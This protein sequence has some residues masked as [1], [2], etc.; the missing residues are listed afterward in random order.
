[1]S[2]IQTYSHK[3]IYL[4]EFTDKTGASKIYIDDIAHALSYICRY[5]GCVDTFYSVGQ[6]SIL[7]YYLA[8]AFYPDNDTLSIECLLHD[9]HEAYVG[10]TIS[11]L[12]EYLRENNITLLDRLE[13]D[14]QHTIYKAFDINLTFP[15]SDEAKMI[16]RALLYWETD[17]NI[18]TRGP[19]W[20]VDDSTDWDVLFF[21]L[22][23]LIAKTFPNFLSYTPNQTK[24]LFLFLFKEEL[25][26]LRNKF[27]DRKDRPIFQRKAVS[28]TDIDL[29]QLIPGIQY[30][31]DF[32]INKE[33][34]MK[35]SISSY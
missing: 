25:K 14:I 10:D 29:T 11:P 23:Q 8:K 31:I 34:K 2:Y 12:K 24:N 32:D 7:A 27:H 17:G 16:D 26:D 3:N 21:K 22:D 4:N 6:H 33:L 19:G 15:M 18:K 13:T 20:D 28:P 35:P 1:M 30:E 9:A 5:N